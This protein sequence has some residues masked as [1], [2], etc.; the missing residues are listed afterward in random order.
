MVP[1]V[2]RFTKQAVGAVI[3]GLLLMSGITASTPVV[4][5]NQVTLTLYVHDG[6]ANGPTLE[7][8]QVTAQDANGNAFDKETNSSG[9]VE[10]SG[11]P[12]TWDFEIRKAG[13]RSVSWTQDITRSTTNHAFFSETLP[14]PSPQSPGVS[15]EP[16][17][18][19]D[20]L[21]PTLEWDGISDADHYALAISDAPYG[22][23]NIV[24][25]PQ[26]V[27]G[28]SHSVPSGKLEPGRDYR[29]NIQAYVNDSWTEVSSTL[30]FQTAGSDDDGDS[31][32]S[33]CDT[34]TPLSDR[35]LADLVQQYF[36]TGTVSATGE[37]IRVTAFAIAMAE[38]SGDPTNCGDRNNP[39]QGDLSV[40]LWQI[41]TGHNPNY[42]IDRLFD[43]DYNAQ[44]AVDI[45]NGGTNWN[46]WCTW[47]STACDGDGDSRYKQYLDDARRALGDGGTSPILELNIRVSPSSGIQGTTFDVTFSAPIR[48]ELP[49]VVHLKKPN[50][51]ISEENI[52]TKMDGTAS[53]SI[54]TDQLPPGDYS[55]WG[56]IGNR[57]IESDHVSF[58][59]KREPN[60]QPN[61]VIS[62]D[63]SHGE[64]PLTVQFDA[65]GSSDPDGSI[66]SYTWN[67]EDGTEIERTD[68][69]QE[70]KF[71]SDGTYSV[72]LTVEDDDGATD[73]TSVEITVNQVP[74][75][76][77][78]LAQGWNF[79]FPIIEDTLTLDQL[80]NQGCSFGSETYRWTGS[81]WQQTDTIRPLQM[82]WV[83]TTSS[84]DIEVRSHPKT[85]SLS[86]NQ[87]SGWYVVSGTQSWD[88]M[89]GNCNVSDGPYGLRGGNFQSHP[90][91]QSMDGIKG[92]VIRVDSSCT[93]EPLASSQAS[94]Q[95]AHASS[96]NPL[97]SLESIKPSF[98]RQTRDQGYN[99]N[100]DL[101]PRGLQIQAQGRSIEGLQI[102]VYSLSGQQIYGDRTTARSL[103][104]N[105]RTRTGMPVANGTYLVA[106]KVQHRGTGWTRSDIRR[107]SILR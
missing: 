51:S 9:Y 83:K 14:V 32:P 75:V 97:E 7:G 58:T 71:T 67:F 17:P 60:E 19:I 54:E 4:A 47:I 36:D 11:V 93:A 61:A 88:A 56:V 62:T 100:L 103:S 22:S 104:W 50:G 92:Y 79:L 57:D 95:V 35:E 31:W 42:D 48:A 59:V 21:T 27:S 29:W 94:S 44:A 10:I 24:Y 43:P 106:V 74:M 15:S 41:N 34:G 84:C 33:Q 3:L 73:T 77:S 39:S 66:E 87:G 90:N 13:Y 86:L 64:V 46:A 5:Q 30:Y 18:T 70:H 102:R 1:G 69:T 55:I 28:T 6:S 37:R 63:R 105:L 81:A 12:G 52:T 78:S 85:S 98:T 107:V 16:G 80:K 65:S 2:D 20:T 40:G 89:K 53:H 8:V 72:T 76:K 45:S 49:I 82:H 99:L 25:N 38:S 96:L 101:N 23:S 68:P 91:S 26:R